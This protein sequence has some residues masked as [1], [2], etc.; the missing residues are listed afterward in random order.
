MK[1]KKKSKLLIVGVLAMAAILMLVAIL[2]HQSTGTEA[3]IGSSIS[4]SQETG[5]PFVENL[6]EDLW[7]DDSDYGGFTT[8]DQLAPD[9]DSIGVLSIEKIDLICH[10]YDSTPETTMDD[11][12]KGAAHYNTTSYWAGNVGLA[13]HNGN[14][15]YSYFDKIHMLEYGD[16][17]TYE[18]TL[19]VRHYAV[20]VIVEIADDD[21]GYLGRTTDNRITLTT[22]ITG[23]PDMRLCVQA[24]EI[25]D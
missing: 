15:D 6:P 4:A 19:G 24:V 11:M 2:V 12:R 13:A 5:A 10:A 18:T 23:K 14:A 7:D 17:I 21:W 22:C 3:K 20:H 1:E 9:S 25:I 8:L 16:I